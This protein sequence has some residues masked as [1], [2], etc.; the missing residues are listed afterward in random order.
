MSGSPMRSMVAKPGTS[1]RPRTWI[2]QRKKP[3]RRAE[4]MTTGGFRSFWTRGVC[5][6]R[7]KFA[8]NKDNGLRRPPALVDK[9]VEGLMSRVRSGRRFSCQH[10]GRP[11]RCGVRDADGFGGKRF[12]PAGVGVA[13]EDAFHGAGCQQS[14]F[15]E[16]TGDG[17]HHGVAT[18]IEANLDGIDAECRQQTLKFLQKFSSKFLAVLIF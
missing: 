16:L 2:I 12:G 4:A 11:F 10:Q 7:M 8:I 14:I 6:M 18:A 17:H 5:G 15:R 13:K 9:V 3:A 1:G